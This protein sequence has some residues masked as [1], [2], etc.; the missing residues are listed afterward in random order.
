M[1]EPSGDTTGFAGD[2]YLNRK[3]PHSKAC[4]AGPADGSRLGNEGNGGKAVD[5]ASRDRTGARARAGYL[6][7]WQETFISIE[8]I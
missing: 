2:V 3:R 5:L 1:V 6:M 8:M 7:G 4:A